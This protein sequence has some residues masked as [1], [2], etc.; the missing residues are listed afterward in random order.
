MS[1]SRH[2]GLRE[3]YWSFARRL[4]AEPEMGI[5][6]MRGVFEQWHLATAEPDG[7]HQAS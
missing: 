2:D 6:G 3:L 1:D 4:E 7:D 5:D